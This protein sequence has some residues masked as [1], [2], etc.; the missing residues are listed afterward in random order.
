MSRCVLL[1]LLV[2][3]GGG[4][5]TKM[6]RR[7]AVAPDVVGEAADGTWVKLSALEGQLAI[8]YFYPKDGTPGCTQEACAFRDAFERYEEAGI[9]I[10]GVSGDHAASHRTFRAE[11]E[12]PFPLVADV[13]GK[14]MAAYGVPSP[15]GMASRVTFLVG[16]DGKIARVFRD[17]DPGVHAEEVLAAVQK[18][19][20]RMPVRQRKHFD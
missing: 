16:R 12:L 7:G 3:C 2:A 8:V 5:E 20:T 19:E 17:V 11:H 13:D 9:V 18:L 4:G 15:L 14:V 1:A 10:F 6:L